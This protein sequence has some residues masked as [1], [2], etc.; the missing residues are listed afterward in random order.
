MPEVRGGRR[1]EAGRAGA[2]DVPAERRIVVRTQPL[3]VLVVSGRRE[4]LPV[5]AAARGLGLRVLVSDGAPDAP[6][7][8]LADAGLAAG[9]CDAEATVAAVR[10]YATVNRIDGVLGVGSDAARTVWAVA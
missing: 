4:A 6:G 7:F 9:V 8:R 2:A 3:T 10:A 1:T 5:I